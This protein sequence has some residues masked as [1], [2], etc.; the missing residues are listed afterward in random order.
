MPFVGLATIGSTPASTH[1][2]SWDAY[3]P[4]IRRGGY[5]SDLKRYPAEGRRVTRLAKLLAVGKD[6]DLAPLNGGRQMESWWETLTTDPMS[7][8][9]GRHE[10][11]P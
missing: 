10:I 8:T 7:K 5:G 4:H 1:P 9:Y 2:F 11:Q 3:R 6:L